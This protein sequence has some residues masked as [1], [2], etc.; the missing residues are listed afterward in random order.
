MRVTRNERVNHR[1]DV[2][3][4]NATLWLTKQPSCTARRTVWRATAPPQTLHEGT[5]HARAWASHPRREVAAKMH[6]RS[7]A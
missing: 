5:A 6:A 7:P 4:R 3:L 1:E 2:K